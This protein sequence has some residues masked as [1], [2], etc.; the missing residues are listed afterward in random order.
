VSMFGSEALA[1]VL[2]AHADTD[3]V[4]R[5]MLVM[6]RVWRKAPQHPQRGTRHTSLHPSRDSL[7]ATSLQLP[8]DEATPTSSGV[9][10]HLKSAF[11]LQRRLSAGAAD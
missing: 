10:G 2:I 6:L 4:L 5:K 8:L 1:Q 7:D 9:P 3:P 11:G